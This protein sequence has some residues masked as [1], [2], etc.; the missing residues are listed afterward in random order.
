MEI[1]I[2][3]L[4][5][6]FS[7]SIPFS[8]LIAKMARKIDIRTTGD[9]NPGAINVLRTS[10]I[11]W[12]IIAFLLDGFKGAVP[13]GIAYSLFGIHGWA[14][15]PVM[16]SPI[17]GHLF[18]PWLKFTGGKGISVTFGVWTGLTLGVGPI[19]WGLLLAFFYIIF[20]QSAWVVLFS[21]LAFGIFIIKY[22]IPHNLFFVGWLAN[23][24]LLVLAHRHQFLTEKPIP[25]KWLTNAVNWIIRCF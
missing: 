17:F 6:Y 3:S 19:I 14:V 22:G 21:F 18:S 20:S 9:H 4:I 2:W 16:L 1:L 23:L 12:F 5:G 24:T 25:R 10:G 15:L 13:T 7:G 11:G 8:L